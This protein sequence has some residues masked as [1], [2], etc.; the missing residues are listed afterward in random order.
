MKGTMH[1]DQEPLLT[2]DDLRGRGWSER[3]I[4]QL[5]PTPDALM[6]RRSPQGSRPVHLYLEERVREAETGTVFA[7]LLEKSIVA[8]ERAARAR[9]KRHQK[10]VQDIQAHVQAFSAGHLRNI[11]SPQQVEHLAAIEQVPLRLVV[12][13]YHFRDA[14]RHQHRHGLG[15]LGKRYMQDLERQLLIRTA[16]VLKQVY[17]WAYSQNHP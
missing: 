3:M 9:E 14:Q 16:E 13:G 6:H 4:Q 15:N 1:T 12:W 7:E 10:R 8:Q 5:L 11:L 17:P 2:S